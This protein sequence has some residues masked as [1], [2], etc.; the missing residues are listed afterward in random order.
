M[1]R[2]EV[3]ILISKKMKLVRIEHGHTQEKMAHILGISK[4]TLV[5]IEKERLVASW[6]TVVAMCALFGD[7]EIL[8]SACGG[9]P[10][11]MV[12]VLGRESIVYRKDRTFGGKIWWEEVDHQGLYRLQQNIISRH[13][14]II[15]Q[16]NYRW[17]ST[18]NK[19]EAVAQFETFIHAPQR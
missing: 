7:S 3:C 15:D 12:T 17:F 11:E 18:F 5:Q 4:K 1:N 13:Y 2:D 6:T 19:E 10:L 9:H 14:R 16:E 8:V